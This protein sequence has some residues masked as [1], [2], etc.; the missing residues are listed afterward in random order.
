MTV[1]EAF[2][3]GTPALVSDLGNAGS[4]IK[5]GVTGMKFNPH[6]PK[7]IADTV[8]RFLEDTDTPWQENTLAQYRLTMTP[9]KNYEMLMDIYTRVREEMRRRK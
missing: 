6:S 5:Q 3:V 1:A 8:A 2:S 7:S 9:E 4:L